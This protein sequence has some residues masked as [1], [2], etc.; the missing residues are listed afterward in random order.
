[1]KGRY[2]HLCDDFENLLLQN[3]KHPAAFGEQSV[4]LSAETGKPLSTQSLAQRQRQSS[5]PARY[6]PFGEPA[7]SDRTEVPVHPMSTDSSHPKKG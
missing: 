2:N 4:V 1:M 7:A 5:V 6:N 3:E